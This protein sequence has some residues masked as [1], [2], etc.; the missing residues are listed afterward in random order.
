M[1]R[2]GGRNQEKTLILNTADKETTVCLRVGLPAPPL[3][4]AHNDVPR[5]LY[6]WTG[7]ARNL[8]KI[9][10]PWKRPSESS[11]HGYFSGDG[12]MQGQG[13]VTVMAK[14]TGRISHQNVSQL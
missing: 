9:K 12:A 5:L 14:F 4:Q 7:N 2:G 11:F 6:C 1:G 3:P 10:E 8:E 13:C